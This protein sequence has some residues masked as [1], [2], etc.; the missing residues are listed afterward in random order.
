MELQSVIEFIVRVTD[1]K[2]ASTL[3]SRAANPITLSEECMSL[4]HELK[5]LIEEVLISPRLAAAL[6]ERCSH[7]ASTMILLKK[8]I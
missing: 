1:T 3:W 5:Q 8:L 6:T 2:V 4:S 7:Q